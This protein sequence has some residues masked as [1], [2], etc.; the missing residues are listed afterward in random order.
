MRK[1]L[2]LIL[3]LMAVSIDHVSGKV[4]TTCPNQ[5]GGYPSIQEA[6]NTADE[7]DTVELL[8]GVYHESFVIDK[9]IILLG[10]PG[11]SILL[12][13]GSEPIVTVKG[14]G[15]E[16]RGLNF[17]YASKGIQFVGA[18][19]GVVLNCEFDHVGSG[20]SIEDSSAITITDNNFH[21][22]QQE[23][24]IM[25]NSANNTIQGNTMKGGIIAVYSRFSGGNF[26]HENTFDLTHDGVVLD[27][28]NSNQV[29][30]NSFLNLIN[31]V[32]TINS[33]GNKVNSNTVNN[34]SLFTGTLFTTRNM[35]HGNRVENVKN[36]AKDLVSTGNLY[37][38]SQVNIT[39]ENFDLMI[40]DSETVDGYRSESSQL[41]ITIRESRL[42]PGYVDI[43]LIIPEMTFQG[44]THSDL[45]L[46]DISSGSPITLAKGETVNDTITLTYQV[47]ENG[48]Y[49]V[50]LEYDDIPP[51][52]II[53][54]A[55]EAY[56]NQ[57]ISLSAEDST[58][59]VD[60]TEYEWVLGDES[61][62]STESI[63]HT[64]TEPG[65]YTITLIVH[66]GYGNIG[67]TSHIV[68]VLE[69]Q[70]EEKGINIYY[71]V[72]VATILIIL[73]M[74]Y[75]YYRPKNEASNL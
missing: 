29:E 75:M 24:V 70:S 27:N 42:D 11:E 45:S 66:D 37:R 39:G 54:G 9:G 55:I 53:S 57:V 3:L 41:N 58:D 32:L 36:Y 22:I 47:T 6:I 4:I 60:I 21:D 38:I 56:V 8:P 62:E 16:I 2:L 48:L 19:D 59:N 17:G 49:Q 25:V 20:I 10:T 28:S 30:G 71:L 14:N 65:E 18:E 61:T 34:V 52:A 13:S 72:I 43:R 15:V 68:T 69:L 31:A 50:L 46:V 67:K 33:G 26:I 51:T 64:Y 23:S 44:R 40:H 5:C 35:F 74:G 12:P 73:I 7:G 1:K 63:I